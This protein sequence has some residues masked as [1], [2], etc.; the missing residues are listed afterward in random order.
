MV[1]LKFKYIVLAVLCLTL[2][3]VA[4]ACDGDEGKEGGEEHKHNI[5]Q[6]YTHDAENHWKTCSGCSEIFELASHT[7]GDWTV[8]I[9]PTPDESGKETRSCTVCGY[10]EERTVNIQMY[11]FEV[12]NTNPTMGNVDGTLSDD[13]AWHGKSMGALTATANTG[14][15]FVG[16]F[17]FSTA[18]EPISTET[19]Y[20][21]FTMPDSDFY[22]E[23]R[24]APDADTPYAVEYYKEKV[25]VDGTDFDNHYVLEYTDTNKTGTTATVVNVTPEQVYEGFTAPAAQ[26]ITVDADGGAVVKFYYTRNQYELTTSA[27]AN[28]TVDHVYNAERFDYG[29]AITLTATAN[30]GYSFDGWY[31][32]AE[33]VS[34][35]A[36]YTLNMPANA[37]TRVAKFTVNTYAFAY[38]SEDTEKGT[39]AC[40]IAS[41]TN[42]NYN[43][44]VTVTATAN[45]GYDFAGWYNGTVIESTDAE[46]TFTMPA[47]AVTLEAQFVAQKRTVNF[48]VDSDV[49]ETKEVDYNTAAPTDSVKAEKPNNE[50]IGWFTDADFKNVYG[51]ETV[52]TD[53]DLYA[54]FNPTAIF[55]T[56]RFFDYDGSQL[57]GNQKIEQGSKPI[58]PANPE[59]TG[60][61]FT[62]W[63]F[64]GAEL[65]DDFT[66]ESDME[67]YAT[68]TEKTYNVRF[69]LSDDAAIGDEYIQEIKYNKTAVKPL[70]PTKEGYTFGK[71]LLN[72]YEFDF[73]APITEDLNIYATWNEIVKPTFTVTFY[74]EDGGKVIDTQ[75]VEEGGDATAPQIP[76]KTGYTFKAWSGEFTNVTANISIYATYDVATCKITFAYYDSTAQKDVERKVTVNYGTAAVAPTNT[77]K[78]GY[79]FDGWDKAFTN[80]TEDIK[81][82]AIYTIKTFTAT[83]YL[84]DKVYATESATYGATFK[85][86]TTPD[87]A[88][89]SFMGWYDSEGF[90]ASFKFTDAATTDVD[91]YGK[92]EEIP[93][94]TYTVRFVD[95]DNRTISE[96]T[97]VEHEAAFAPGNPSRTGYTFKGWN[98]AFSDIVENIEVQA[99]YTKNKY[100]VTY[101]QEDG[102]TLIVA[103]QVEYLDDASGLVEAPKVT[104]KTF[105]RWSKDLTSIT[106]NVEVYAIYVKNAVTVR[107]IDDDGETELARQSVEYGGHAS[108]PSTPVKQGYIFKAWVTAA[109]ADVAFDF[110]TAITAETSVYAKWEAASGVYSVYFKDYDG[111][112][113][114]NVQRIV[115]GYYATEPSAPAITDT[116]KEFDGWYVEG[117][118]DKFDFDNTKIY[119]T[120]TL[121]ARTKAKTAG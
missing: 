121:V 56:V 53:L 51:G 42:V 82:T 19:T 111:A 66:V 113:Y 104:G 112:S 7:F 26:Q 5:S 77:A 76:V 15:H 96:Q 43:Q 33:K 29:E 78:T 84:G 108:V 105:S 28:G 109:G 88:G 71:W 118:D 68:Y 110:S 100:T 25:D 12:V 17:A 79:T 73:S 92:L 27:D 93:I 70:T 67:I 39:V 16:W 85:I 64:N 90:T 87:V 63:T 60:Y 117:T 47:N 69:Y 10:S 3:V 1:K 102:S 24:F 80:V 35:N 6:T 57:G 72:G 74:D 107:F 55:Y 61:D 34:T 98:K 101:Y 8:S 106:K 23:A 54:K 99:Q 20:P 9:A 91:V 46:Y 81:V 21:A 116:D 2:F 13:Q 4:A 11:R 48:Y 22:L 31:D 30:T 114:G 59:K 119:N 36:E 115:A 58:M 52:K 38:S 50:F 75:T 94:S 40:D 45:T 44:S 120:I 32:G 65:N 95:F 37:V 86:P 14:Y 18:S 49:I 62:K 41:G 103:K 97:V 89:Y 83:F